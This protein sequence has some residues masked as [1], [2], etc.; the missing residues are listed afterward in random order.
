MSSATRTVIIVGSG[1]AGYSAAVYAARANLAPLVF[2]SSVTAGGALMTTTEVENF[3]G[4]PD[5]IMGPD[6]MMA[7][8]AESE[9]C[10]AELIADDVTE[11]DLTGD[12]KTISTHSKTYQAR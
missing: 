1:P 12:V 9:R 11:V 8:R 2:E 3:T 7:M 6:L 5:G 4:F 10:G